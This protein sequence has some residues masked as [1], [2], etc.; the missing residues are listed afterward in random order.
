[1]KTFWSSTSMPRKRLTFSPEFKMEVV[2]ESFQPNI[3]LQ[4]LAD[5]HH[6]SIKNI[7]NWKQQ[8][9][10]K[11]HLAFDNP[12]S[13]ETLSS[14][15]QENAKLEK[16]LKQLQSEHDFVTRKLKELNL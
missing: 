4:Q 11:A 7:M 6:T 13:K 15:K 3:T 2:F 16:Q 1:M 14:L 12:A 9:F 10:E 8:F 5:K